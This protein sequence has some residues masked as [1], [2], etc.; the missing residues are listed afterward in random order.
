MQEVEII[1]NAPRNTLSSYITLH[2]EYYTQWGDQIYVCF[3][4]TPQRGRVLA[5]DAMPMTSDGRGGWSLQISTKNCSGI[6]YTYCLVRNGVVLRT[7]WQAGHQ[8]PDCANSLQIFDSWIDVPEDRPFY[9]SAFT[10]SIF[11]RTEPDPVTPNLTAGQPGTLTFRCEAASLQPGQRIA[12]CGNA[13]V[14]GDWNPQQAALMTRLSDTAWTVTVSHAECNYPIYFKF[15]IYDPKQK[16]WVWESGDNRALIPLRQPAQDEVLWT[17]FYQVN[18]PI[19][20]WR[21]AGV[22]IPVFSLRSH[23]DAGIGEFN[24]LRLMVDWCERT[25]QKVIQILPVNDTTI[26]RTWR[27]S[28]PYNSNSTFA[29]NPLYIHLEDLGTLPDEG[30]MERFH[31]QCRN[32]NRLPAI[33]LEQVIELKWA[34]L[35]RIYIFNG[36]RDL[37]SPEYQAFY[38]QNRYW[39][40][41]YAVYS[42]LRDKYNTAHFNEWNEP[43]SPELVERMTSPAST[44]HVQVDF[45]KYIQFHLH[46]QLLS[47]RNYAHAHGIVLKGDIP[48]G[49]SRY[50][51]DAWVHPSLFHLDS[52]A[53]APPDSFDC[54]G[55]NWGFPTYNWRAMAAENYR[56]FKE[57]FVKMAEYFDAY[58]IDHILGFFRIWEVPMHAVQGLLG[59][60]NPAMPLTAEEMLRDYGFR[61]DREQLLPYVTDETLEEL[62]ADDEETQELVKHKFLDIPMPKDTRYRFC[63]RFGTQRSVEGYFRSRPES[64]ELKKQ[65]FSLLTDVLFIEDPHKPGRFHPRIN[66]MDTFAFR[67]LEADQQEAYRRL[68]KDFF[69]HRHNDFWREEAMR[70]LPVL[71]QATPMLAC[72][73]DLGMIPSCVPD[74]MRYLR[75][76]SLEIQRMP[77]GFAEFG[78]PKEYPY[79]SVCTTSSH[80]LS[81]L[82]VWWEEDPERTQRYYRDQLKG[83]GQAPKQA[84]P[85]I[86][87]K[88]IE[89]HLEAPSMLVILPIQ[90]WLAIDGRLRHPEPTEER[91]N[92]PSNPDNYWRYRLHVP[93]EELLE[94]DSFN[95]QVKGL[96]RKHGR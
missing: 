15:V 36:A 73:E 51:V 82:R 93:L 79:Y 32:L 3:N 8:L 85:W 76:L 44:T 34:Y 25:G 89:E 94:A 24:D 39:L 88:M 14:L 46:R 21:G 58:R 1:A 30:E 64:A 37:A 91:I 17:G 90:D 12:V 29:L 69:Y 2:L 70:K 55:Q 66:G 95:R 48:I 35:R 16:Q 53:G 6:P 27:D 20:R 96:I 4:S 40:D 7:E 11:R 42:Y 67:A 49:I 68:H 9:S 92:T 54:N 31:R 57:R 59:Y 86:C 65:L 81:N 74:V 10:R 87:A 23:A 72:G 52:Q 5:L 47:V 84:E 83:I 61:F 62:F 26:T 19:E 63:P 13:A 56:W 60:F 41:D 75:I 45:Y 80:D 22:A 38:E 33:D 71:L 43:Y 78:N 50:S 18:N 77:K 28:Y